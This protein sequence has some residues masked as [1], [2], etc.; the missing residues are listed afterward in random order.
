M[1]LSWMWGEQDGKASGMFY[2][3]IYHYM[4]LYV[5]ICHY[6]ALYHNM[7]LYSE[8]RYMSLYGHNIVTYGG[9]T[10]HNIVACS[11]LTIYVVICIY[12]H[13]S[14]CGQTVVWPDEEVPHE[15]VEHKTN[16]RPIY[17]IICPYIL[18]YVT[19]CHGHYICSMP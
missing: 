10:C 16:I 14:N 13:G 3:I 1:H 2:V 8:Y 4:S 7:S 5:N 11:V 9:V 15:N 17:V 12:H 18:L 19:I 6:M